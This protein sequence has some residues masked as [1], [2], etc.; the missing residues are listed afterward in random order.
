MSPMAP[1]APILQCVPNTPNVPNVPNIPNVPKCPDGAIKCAPQ[2]GRL[3]DTKWPPMSP[4]CPNVPNTP[5]VPNIPNPPNPPNTPSVP[6]TPNVPSV[7]SPLA[8]GHTFPGSSRHSR[9]R[10]PS[11]CPHLGSFLRAWASW[12]PSATKGPVPGQGTVRGPCRSPQTSGS[13]DSASS[14]P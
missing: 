2:N 7:P 10:W 9:C 1:M 13:W 3:R 6:N 8:G 5:N 4:M 11:R 12:S 14:S